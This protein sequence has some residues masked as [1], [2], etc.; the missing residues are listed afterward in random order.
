MLYKRAPPAIVPENINIPIVLPSH[1]PLEPSVVDAATNENEM[2]PSLPKT[3]E[4]AAYGLLDE[5]M[6]PNRHSFLQLL[7]MKILRCLNWVYFY[8]C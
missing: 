8:L 1:S 4:L 7:K 2:I 6:L 3:V 5:N